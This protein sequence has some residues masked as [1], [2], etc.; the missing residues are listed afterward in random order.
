MR[1]LTCFVLLAAALASAESARVQAWKMLDDAVAEKSADKRAKAMRALGL[2][3][4]DT[5]ATELAQRGL[6]DQQTVVR[7]AAANAL[8]QMRARRA[9][10][11][12]KS[13]LDDG[14]TSV[15]LAA[16]NALTEMDDKS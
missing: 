4:N 9:I 6:K 10:P 12:L 14:E 5:K 3:K 2:V 8:G 16:A 1:R 13:A 11:A 7:E 15:V